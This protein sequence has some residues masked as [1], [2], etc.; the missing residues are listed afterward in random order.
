MRR[1]IVFLI[2][3]SILFIGSAQNKQLLYDFTDLP[4]ALM[5]NPGTEMYYKSHIGVPVLSHIHFNYGLR[6]FTPSQIIMKDGID[7]NY[8]LQNLINSVSNNDHLVINQQLELLNFGWSSRRYYNTYFSAG[9]YEEF[10]FIGYVPKEIGQLALY[11]NQYH[12]NQRQGFYNIT[13]KMD[14]MNVF[15]FGLTKKVD[16]YLTIGGRIKLYS[17]ILNFE[18]LDN[19]GALTTYETPNGNNIYNHDIANVNIAIKTAGYA[20][21]RDNRQGGLGMLTSV[22]G[23]S[24]FGGN[25]GYGL[26]AGFTYT[27]RDQWEV[28]GSVVDLGAIFYNKDTEIYTVAL[29]YKFDGVNASGTN[30]NALQEMISSIHTDTLKSKYSS[31]RPTKLNGSIKFSWEELDYSTCNCRVSPTKRRYINSVGL[32]AFS[33]FRPRRP[34]FAASLYY[35]RR[36]SNS[37]QAKIA[38]TI[39]DYSF[40]NVGIIVSKSIRSLNLYLALDNLLEFY[41]IPKSNG[42]SIQMGINFITQNKY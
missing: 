20:S 10:D 2:T 39:D 1:L 19:T 40:T 29:D 26:D 18:T 6:G 30:T 41:Q 4:Q 32:Q 9:M 5:L 33:Q 22:V 8:K 35:Y 36:F 14:L 27:L 34:I 11:G 3:I 7:I 21:L 28:T 15:H 17:S 23:K 12:I 31:M 24:F 37:T 13:A 16:D 38:Y 25:I 42:M